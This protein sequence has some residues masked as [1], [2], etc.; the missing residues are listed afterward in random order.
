VVCNLWPVVV[1]EEVKL[2]QM[3]LQKWVKSEKRKEVRKSDITAKRKKN[4]NEME[5]ESWVEDNCLQ[6]CLEDARKQSEY[7]F[8]IG[9]GC[10]SYGLPVYWAE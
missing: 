2:T 4:K 8:F 7:P 1:G 5:E 6:K 3:L 10:V 9:N